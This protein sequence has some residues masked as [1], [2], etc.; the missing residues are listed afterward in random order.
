MAMTSLQRMNEYEA[1]LRTRKE[2]AGIGDSLSRLP[3]LAERLQRKSQEA[4]DKMGDT[5]ACSAEGI[6]AAIRSLG[7]SLA[8]QNES[9]R[10]TIATMSTHMEMALSDISWQLELS[11]KQLQAI[12]ETLQHPKTA[13][14]T[15]SRKR[16]EYALSAELYE[17][18]ERDLNHAVERNPYDFLA[19]FTLGQTYLLGLKDL[20]K[21]RAAFANAAK[22]ARKP[23]PSCAADALLKQA[24]VC[25]LQGDDG[26][27]FE[28]AKQATEIAPLQGAAMYAAAQYGASLGTVDASV[29]QTYL[30]AALRADPRFSLKAYAD[31]IFAGPARGILDDVVQRLVARHKQIAEAMAE[32]VGDL[33][34][35]TSI[36]DEG[37]S[38]ESSIVSLTAKSNQL[39]TRQTLLELLA[40]IQVYAQLKQKCLEHLSRKVAHRTGQ[41][42]HRVRETMNR[43]EASCAK[44]KEAA[45]RYA[46]DIAALRI[47]GVD[48]K[49]KA[50]AN[51][52]TAGAIAAAVGAMG[53]C[54]TACGKTVRN[55]SG[56]QWITNI[57]LGAGILGGLAYLIA[58]LIG[59]SMSTN[60]AAE[61]ATEGDRMNSQVSAAAMAAKLNE[62]QNLQAAVANLSSRP[63]PAYAAWAHQFLHET[64]KPLEERCASLERGL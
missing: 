53:G 43:V 61:R 21:A 11:S 4:F 54:F 16:G 35:A 41:L 8:D 50:Q 49:K 24:T 20:E 2:L 42:Q 19:H 56:G 48:S 6:E 25:H 44:H 45:L 29:I 64:M 52:L 60:D 38:P 63:T 33:M 31:P 10:Q 22:Y 23:A 9:I 1:I 40:L 34:S 30:E 58:L 32:E 39:V 17:D 26:A 51:A 55:F 37:Q 5:L 28:L 47:R 7:G 12:L 46:Q 27:A 13:D 15:E 57:L 3:D 18:A 14:A 36:L 62:A 59:N